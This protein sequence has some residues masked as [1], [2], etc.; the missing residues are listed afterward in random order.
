MTFE[1]DLNFEDHLQKIL[2]LDGHSG[3]DQFKFANGHENISL[4]F[5]D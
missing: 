4:N 5:E 1:T 3:L 2:E